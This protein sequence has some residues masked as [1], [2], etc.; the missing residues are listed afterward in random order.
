MKS[1]EFENGQFN[2][3]LLIFECQ[4]LMDEDKL[5][6]YWSSGFKLALTKPRRA[7]ALSPAS[8]S[9]FMLKFFLNGLYIPKHFM[10]LVHI[11]HDKRSRSNKSFQDL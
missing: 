2:L 1:C 7:Y 6:N 4:G 9:T 5:Q 10:D 8:A 11:W 3:E